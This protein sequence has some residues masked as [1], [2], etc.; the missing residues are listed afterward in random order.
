MGSHKQCPN[1]HY[2]D[3]NLSECPYCSPSGIGSDTS[4]N[5]DTYIGGTAPVDNVDV[6][7]EGV[8]AAANSFAGNS[9][10]VF[11]TA[12]VN[13]G[14]NDGNTVALNVDDDEGKTVILRGADTSYQ[15]G[16]KKSDSDQSEHKSGEQ[17]SD[18]D[19]PE[20]LVVGWLVAVGG[21]YK[22]K[23]FE[24]H[25]GYTYFGSKEGDVVLDKDK[26]ISKSKCFYVLYSAKN[27][28]Y[29]VGAGLSRNVVYLND[30]EL[31]AGSSAVLNPY[32]VIEIGNS[33]FR[34]VPFCSME[35]SW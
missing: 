9:Y 14:S 2:Y 29:K 28:R 26:A 19:E 13:F 4:R 17:D 31:D 27:I 16:Q 6:S 8:T 22:G 34:F 32:D 3:Q 5:I 11:S 21:P 25:H 35:F 30:E 20:E 12:N 15:K 1:G 23:S 18:G 33:K 10:G 7:S 24:L